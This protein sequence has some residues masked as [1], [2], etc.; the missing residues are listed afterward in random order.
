MKTLCF[1]LLTFYG[2]CVVI[3]SKQIPDHLIKCYK[4]ENIWGF[5]LPLN[6]RV[7]VDIIRKIER[8]SF[9]TL[10]MKTLT[11]SL[12]RR[13][14]LD[15]IHR[16]SEVSS[17][18]RILPFIANQPQRIKQEIIEELIPG[19]DKAFPAVNLTLLEYCTLHQAI[20]NTI[21]YSQ[22]NDEE[23]FCISGPLEKIV[24][25]INQRIRHCYLLATF[26]R[27]LMTKCID[28]NLTTAE[29]LC[30]K[31]NGVI[32]TKFGTISL[33][34]VINA[35]A[36]SLVP[37]KVQLNTL[38]S[39]R[40][41][42]Y[43]KNESSKFN[44]NQ[45]EV[46]LIVPK[47]QILLQRSMWIQSLSQS[48]LKLNNI[49][50]ASLAGE[51]AEVVVY[52]GPIFTSTMSIGATGFWNSSIRP[53]VFYVSNKRGLFDATRAEIIGSIDG[54]V[55][56]KNL[57]LWMENFDSLRLSQILDMYYSNRG[58]SFNKNIKACDRGRNFIHI[59]P[60]TIIEEE[61]FAI[62]KLLAYRNGAV[63]MNDGDL[64]KFVNYATSTFSYYV[65]NHI[66]TESR[67]REETRQPRVELIV[68]FDGS[69]SPE[70]TND[71]LSVL[72]EDVDV[73]LFGSKMGLIHATS[74][75]WLFNLTNSPASVYENL[76]NLRKMKWPDGLNYTA[77]LEGIFDYLEIAWEENRKMA[78]IGNVGQAL[79]VLAPRTR[80]S[81]S[82]QQSALNLI[83][84]IKQK[85]PEMHFLYFVM[86][87][88]ADIF[89]KFIT[90]DEDHL[91]LSSTIDDIRKLLVE[92]PVTLRPVFGH[93]NT[94]GIGTMQM[95]DYINLEESITY[96]LHSHWKSKIKKTTLTFH[97][98]GYGTIK[99]CFRTKQKLEDSPR[100]L[101][102][103][104]LSAFED[105]K[106]EDFSPCT[107]NNCS[108][109]FYE[110]QYQKSLMK[111]AE[112]DC[113]T[114]NQVR[115]ILQIENVVSS[116]CPTIISRYNLVI[117]TILATFCIF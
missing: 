102:C 34:S 10:H 85:H 60:G 12:L 37:Q 24:D 38:L 71:F 21:W 90:S 11:T 78:N 25:D 106:F 29:K 61:T 40:N 99:I 3:S 54:L 89:Q 112:I 82:D 31:E 115:Y 17:S 68:T 98:V 95:E 36:A 59:A 92:I 56:A 23:N 103:Q 57:P 28:E 15:G 109:L 44:F 73:S 45:E 83:L 42:K 94:L 113:K 41:Q 1:L 81:A 72:V 13:F 18:S 114:P 65:N 33:G 79:L 26:A 96:K 100:E 55:I 70:Y 49:W 8:Q 104:T 39:L 46:D 2:V 16:N 5:Q 107:W 88:V 51:L 47:D 43:S 117:I 91:I 6:L 9:S 19:D 116:K 4:N 76:R 48:P 86:D 101:N 111:C 52:Q 32:L 53:A 22:R 77:V 14:K 35:I 63:Y 50:A 74:G 20:S 105:I 80:L 64:Q 27:D 108:H 87:G 84:K 93:N 110:V 7:I 97:G 30:P 62:S 66:F 69:W 67:C 75:K 58:V